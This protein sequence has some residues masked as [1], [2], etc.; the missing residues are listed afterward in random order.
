MSVFYFYCRVLYDKRFSA[1]HYPVTDE[2]APN[3]RSI[4]QNPMDMATLLQ[5]VDSG[6]YITCSAFLQDFDLI[7]SNAKVRLSLWLLLLT[8]C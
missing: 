6:Q 1:F 2:D 7:V 4:I 8:A 5:R 3:Y